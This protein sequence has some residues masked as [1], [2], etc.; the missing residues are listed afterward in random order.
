MDAQPREHPAEPEIYLDMVAGLLRCA[1]EARSLEDAFLGLE[2]AGIMLRVDRSVTPTMAKAPTLG[3][4]E[5]RP[6]AQYRQRRPARSHHHSA[7]RR[8][9]PRRWVSPRR[10]RRRGR[11]L[12]LRRA[13]VHA[14]DPDLAARGDHPAA[15]PGRLPVLGAAMAGYVEATRDDDTERNRVCRPSSFG[16]TL[17]DW[18]VMNA[19]GMRNAAALNTEPDLKAFAN[20][21]ALNPARV[22]PEHTGSA[23][24]DDAQNR[25][26]SYA[27]PGLAHLAAWAGLEA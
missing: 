17:V 20:Q 21:I 4:W 26:Q 27:G 2:E 25:I 14:P 16:N 6:A 10:R 3:I 7:A 13:Q 18:A 11:Q 5:V 12:R 22:P 8:D 24:V 9:R 23:A 1:A 15:G 19:V